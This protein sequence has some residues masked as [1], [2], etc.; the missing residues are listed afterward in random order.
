MRAEAAGHVER[1]D[2]VHLTVDGQGDRAVVARQHGERKIELCGAM[3]RKGNEAVRD[4][5]S[6]EC[7]EDAFTLHIV[8]PSGVVPF[9]SPLFQACDENL[10]I[11]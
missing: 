10:A 1:V 8:F 6:A 4:Q 2:K 3:T 5:P 11:A 9:A 7:E